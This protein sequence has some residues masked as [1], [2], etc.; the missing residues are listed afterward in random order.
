[1]LKEYLKNNVLLTDGAM[2]TYYHK[3]SKAPLPFCELE[4]LTDNDIIE[5]IHKEYIN[6]GAKL[7][8]TNTF[9]ANTTVL[10]LP[11]ENI[12]KIIKNSYNTAKKAADGKDVFI[13]CSIGPNA[14][15]SEE[16]IKIADVF[17]DLGADIFIFETF[18]RLD[19]VSAAIDH[20]KQKEPSAFILMEFALSDAGMTSSFLSANRIIEQCTDNKNIDALG[21]N[22]GIGPKHMENVLASLNTHSYKPLSALPNAGYPEIIN[23]QVEYVMNPVYYAELVSG[24]H[25]LGV[26]IIGGCCGT[27][28]EHIRLLSE[29]IQGKAVENRVF[30]AQ[31]ETKSMPKSEN[32]FHKKLESDR[33]LYAVELDPPFKTNTDRLIEGAAALKKVGVDIVTIADSPM[34]KPRV[35]STIISAKIRRE[36][37]MEV[38]PHFCCR[39]RNAIALRSSLLGAYVE[40]IRNALVVTG[41][42]V[43]GEERNRI[44]SVFNMQ[45]Y[46][47]M[48]MI[49][50]MNRE[51]FTDEPIYYGGAV[52]FNVKNKQTEY[53]RLLKKRE[54][55]AKF[56]LTQPIF[57]DDTIE[58]ISQLPKERDFKIFGGVMPLVNYKNAQFINNEMAGINIPE[59]YIER[60]SPDFS[61]EEGENTGIAIALEIAYK[62][63]PYV[64]GFYFITPF[65]RYEM[66]I[67]ILEKIKEEKNV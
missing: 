45:S 39:D 22:C 66:I 6:S 64:D 10:E 67:K 53:S 41:D 4:A 16:Y 60:F 46:S 31:A 17:L 5:K 59:H 32:E 27:T 34:G 40:G 3:I 13:G 42:P 14:E 18:D 36:T 9:N 57:T 35:D 52:N 7:I 20:I 1:M 58:F 28:P 19:K 24:Y 47:F 8:R 29:R 2:G 37:G 23:G 50:E 43:P 38:L 61:R 30:A 56:F 51:V 54:A 15:D 12:E 48:N 65:N 62:I 21:F 25:K 63:R 49:G 55:G 26:N 44:K 33:F 11:F